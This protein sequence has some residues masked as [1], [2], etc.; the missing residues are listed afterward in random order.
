MGLARDLYIHCVEKDPGYAPAWARL[1]RCYRF[2][3]K[4]Q[5]ENGDVHRST[6]A[7][8]ERAFTLNPDLALAHSA[9]TPI[10][11]DM[12]QAESAMVRL[13]RRATS[14]DNNPDLFCALV[15]ACRYCG[16]LDA[17]LAAH[18]KALELDPNVH[19][20]VAH[21]FFAMAEFE[22]S[23]YWY[24]TG[25]GLYLDATALASLG[26][27]QE[28]ST[29][30]WTRKD[31]FGL[32]PRQMNSLDALPA[33]RSRQ[34]RRSIAGNRSRCYSRSGSAILSGASGI[35]TRCH[36]L[37]LRFSAAICR[38][39]LLEHRKS[40]TRSLA[41]TIARHRQI[42]ADIRTRKRARGTINDSVPRRRR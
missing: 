18:R 30:L 25:V 23:L 19:T 22:K 24:G 4:F 33:R 37:G 17:S 11:C 2:M 13:L 14:H 36:R 34:S 28:A 1:G 40:D 35:N 21:T 32:M 39:R 42:R 5:P 9:Y 20:S 12:G 3:E 27:E 31:K 41:R 38:R 16:Q 8:I 7:A 29:L 26:R 10:Q 15:H 6:V